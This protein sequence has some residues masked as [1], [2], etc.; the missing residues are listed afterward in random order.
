M[1]HL[2][3][4]SV[5]DAEQLWKMQIESFSALLEKYQDFETSPANE[6]L[7]K[8]EMRLQQAFTFFYFIQHDHEMVGAIR[9]VDGKDG[10]RKRI[11]PIFVL[12]AYRNL[13][14]AAQAICEAE[15]LHG[16]EN[17]ALDTILQEFGLCRFYEN[18]GYRDTGKRT[19]INDKMTLIFYEK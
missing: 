4:A 17:W 19:V 13:G 16:A 12:P 8:V 18:L 1:I 10:T 6:P 3:R 2:S 9:V 14:I 5:S 11:S 15:R 7:E